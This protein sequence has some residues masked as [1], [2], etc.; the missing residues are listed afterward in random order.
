M[1]ADTQALERKLSEALGLAVTIDH[2]G[3]QGG[4]VRIG[5]ATIEQLE[6]VCVLLRSARP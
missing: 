6:D 1:S 3:D 4:E 5:Y 2:R